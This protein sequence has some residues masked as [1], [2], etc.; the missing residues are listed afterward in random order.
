MAHYYT[1]DDKLLLL[2]EEEQGM[3]RY[4]WQLRS[5]VKDNAVFNRLFSGSLE[6]DEATEADIAAAIRQRQI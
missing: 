1:T 5:W 6:V 4:D 2:R 3:F